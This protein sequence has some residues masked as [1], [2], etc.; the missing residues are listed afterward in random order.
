M[1]QASNLFNS[2]PRITNSFPTILN[3]TSESDPRSYE[4]TYAVTNYKAQKKILRL[5]RDSNP[6]LRDT[7][8]MLYQVSY[9][10]SLEAG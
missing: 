5:Q 9:E 4:V 8:A 6:D 10:A 3:P 7:G 1:L 2:Q